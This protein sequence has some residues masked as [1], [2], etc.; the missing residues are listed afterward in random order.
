MPRKTHA[1]HPD[2]VRTT[3]SVTPPPGQTDDATKS[4]H[5]HWQNPIDEALNTLPVLL[6]SVLQRDDG[7]LRIVPDG[8]GKVIWWKWKFIHGKHAG[9]YVMVRGEQAQNVESLRVL[10]RKLAQVDRGESRPTRDSYYD[11]G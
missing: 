9:H 8:D 5:S 10:A 1:Q 4:H 3:A 6:A 7:W 11:Q 2:H